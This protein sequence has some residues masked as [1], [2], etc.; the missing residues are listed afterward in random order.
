MLQDHLVRLSRKIATRQKSSLNTYFG[1]GR[2]QRASGNVIPRGWFEG[3]VI[4]DIET[5]RK[6]IYPNGNFKVITD[7]GYTFEC[8]SQGDYHK[9]IRS[10]GSLHTLGKWLKLKLQKSGALAPLTLVTA[11]TFEKYGQ[12]NLRLYKLSKGVYFMEFKPKT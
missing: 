10:T 7:D 1:K 6:E 12:D 4:V 2:W 9:N 8:R 5:T 3:E 11:E